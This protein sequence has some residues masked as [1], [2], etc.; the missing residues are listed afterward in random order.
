MKICNLGL[1]KIRNIAGW[2]KFDPFTRSD[3]AHLS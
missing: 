3:T 2:V 1:T